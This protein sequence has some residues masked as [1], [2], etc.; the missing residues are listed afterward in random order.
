MKILKGNLAM[1]INYIDE[2]SLDR[3]AS[4]MRTKFK[5]ILGE[6]Y[7]EFKKEY[8]ELQEELK[9]TDEQVEYELGKLVRE[10]V[11]IDDND[12]THDMLVSVKYSVEND[13]T[14][15]KGQDADIYELVCQLFDQVK[16]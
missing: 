14:K 3:Q 7:L 6:H 10:S 8:E 2:L 13:N 5:N 11:G 1:V 4:R 9:N 16:E 15:Y 12:E